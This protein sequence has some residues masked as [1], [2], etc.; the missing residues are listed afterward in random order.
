[1]PYSLLHL[2][3][4]PII[5]IHI[6]I[7]SHLVALPSY[8]ISHTIY[9]FIV[10]ILP[11]I[12]IYRIYFNSS[13]GLSLS[14][15]YNSSLLSILPKLSFFPIYFILLEAIY[16]ILFIHFQC[17]I[18]IKIALDSLS[19]LHSSQLFSFCTLCSM[20]FSCSHLFFRIYSCA[21]LFLIL[22]LFHFIIL[23]HPYFPLP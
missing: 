10:I 16:L 4:V 14:F 11:N 15:L 8:H 2:L 3:S 1:M 22:I 17:C 23:K 6:F 21:C 12:N 13:F 9:D 5:L 20:S 19:Q 18:S 7:N